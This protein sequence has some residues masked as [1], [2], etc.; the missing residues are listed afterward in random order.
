MLYAIAVVLIFLWLIERIEYRCKGAASRFGAHGSVARCLRG[1][2]HGTPHG[3]AGHSRRMCRACAT[4]F[5][6]KGTFLSFPAPKINPHL[7]R[8]D[9][10]SAP[11]VVSSNTIGG[12]VHVLLAIVVI[13]VLL[14]LI[15]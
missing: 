14:C 4:A 13:M 5:P 2:P 8:T 11:C 6:C 3:G 9:T 15:G 7:P 12:F 1:S 10:Q